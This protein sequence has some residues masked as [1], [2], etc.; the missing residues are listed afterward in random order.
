MGSA[1][2]FILLIK[3][4]TVIALDFVKSRSPLEMEKQRAIAV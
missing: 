2:A 4:K 3:F 1:I